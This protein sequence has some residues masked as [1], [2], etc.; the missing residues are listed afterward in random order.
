MYPEQEMEQEAVLAARRNSAEDLGVKWEQKG[1]SRAVLVKC[2]G[3]LESVYRTFAAFAPREAYESKGGAVA[4]H[5]C[6]NGLRLSR[7]YGAAF[8]AVAD[9]T[10]YLVAKEEGIT[11]F[12]TAN[13]LS[14]SLTDLH[15]RAVEMIM[16]NLPKILRN[17]CASYETKKGTVGKAEGCA[18]Y[19]DSSVH[20]F[21][22]DRARKIDSLFGRNETR[23]ADHFELDSKVLS[24]AAELVPGDVI[25][26]KNNRVGTCTGEI[27]R[28][29]GFFLT[30]RFRDGCEEQIP[31]DLVPRRVRRFTGNVQDIVVEKTE[32]KRQNFYSVTSLDAFPADNE[33]EGTSL[34]KVLPEGKSAE[35]ALLDNEVRRVLGRTYC[36]TLTSLVRED[37]AQAIMLCYFVRDTL[38]C[39][40][41]HYDT[42]LLQMEEGD[43]GML[44]RQLHELNCLILSDG[45]WESGLEAELPH[46]TRRFSVKELTQAK[47]QA[48]KRLCK[49]MSRAMAA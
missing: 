32:E 48:K 1:A 33:E 2:L 25:I 14:V 16:G 23:A 35:E 39:E 41:T 31:W 43:P 4:N 17:V 46:R 49:D 8:E 13:D 3:D 26:S 10:R 9:Y 27:F 38:C 12:I 19:I 20:N 42:I 22:V 30:F 15:S 29:G 21:L 37:F 5:P 6:W 36:K 18:L 28:D 47:H 40:L 44:L 24:S 45:D 34:I 11:G 7:E